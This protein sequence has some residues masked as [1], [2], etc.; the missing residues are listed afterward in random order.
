ME[1]FVEG[2][3]AIKWVPEATTTTRAEGARFNAGVSKKV[4]RACDK[5]LTWAL[6]KSE[7]E[8]TEEA[9]SYTYTIS[10]PST[11]TTHPLLFI[12]ALSTN[13]WRGEPVARNLFAKAFTLVKEARSNSHASTVLTCVAATMVSTALL[14]LLRSLRIEGYSYAFTSMYL[15][16]TSQNQ[17]CWFHACQRFSNLI[18][19]TY[20]RWLHKD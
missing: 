18:S 10:F 6:T 12:P 3:C 9:A 7:C 14:A 8:S 13:K 17:F 16:P 5:W 15:L 11:V 20:S 1:S 2:A 19:N 4:K